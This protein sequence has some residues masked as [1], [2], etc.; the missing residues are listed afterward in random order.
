MHET[1]M[2]AIPKMRTV[3]KLRLTGLNE[4]AHKWEMKKGKP[5]PVYKCNCGKVF[6]PPFFPYTRNCPCG[7]QIT[8]VKP[9]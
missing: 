9:T 4:C 6:K 7:A 8:V 2:I 3:A 5:K 1:A